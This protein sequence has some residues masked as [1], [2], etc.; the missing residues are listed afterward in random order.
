MKKRIAAA[1]ALLLLASS[2][3]ACK[4]KPSGTDESGTGGGDDTVFAPATGTGEAAATSSA[5]TDPDGA[6]ETL[7]ETDT[8]AGEET[9]TASAPAEIG[10]AHSRQRTA[11][12]K[13]TRFRIGSPP[14]PV[15]MVDWS[16]K[17]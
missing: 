6:S 16:T 7:P 9:G 4:G 2:V 10:S 14:L 3:A 15:F 13:Q 8:R 12:T 1:L 17:I 11:K 5:A